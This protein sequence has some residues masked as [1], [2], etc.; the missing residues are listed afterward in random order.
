[1]LQNLSQEDIQAL[2]FSIFE[3]SLPVVPSTTQQ[4]AEQQ[5]AGPRLADTLPFIT[6]GAADRALAMVAKVRSGHALPSC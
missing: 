1:M 6:Q 3:T 5:Q 4:Q 2:V